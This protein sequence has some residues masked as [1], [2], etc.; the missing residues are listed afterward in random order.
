MAI[1]PPGTLLQLMYIKERLRAVKPCRFVEIGP[2]AGDTS[3][4]LLSLD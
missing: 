3:G 1:L 4:L 2:G